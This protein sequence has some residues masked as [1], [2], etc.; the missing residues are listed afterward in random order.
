MYQT[1]NATLIKQLRKVLREKKGLPIGILT[2]FGP[3]NKTI[4]KIVAIIVEK[5]NVEPLLRKWIKPEILSDPGV[6]T[7]IGQYFLDH[8]TKDIVIAEGVLGCP[9]EE[10]VDYPK[11][12]DCPQCPYWKNLTD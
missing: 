9:H 1:M 12:E 3:D 10:G 7:E 8:N 4:T 11:G 5:S 2:Y 6:A